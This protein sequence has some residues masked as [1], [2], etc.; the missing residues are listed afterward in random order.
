MTKAPMFYDA[1]IIGGG[2]AGLAAAVTYMRRRD[3]GRLVILE[4]KESCGRKLLATGNGRC[5]V[6]N[7]SA[8]GYE[9]I[10]AFFESMGVLLR[11]EEAG[12]AYPMSGKAESVL[13]ALLCALQSPPE[14]RLEPSK[15]HLEPVPTAAEALRGEQ[16]RKRCVDIRTDCRVGEILRTPGGQG[17]YE[18]KAENGAL[19][20]APRVLIATGGKAGPAF[21]SHGDG[22]AFARSLGHRVE[23]IRPALVPVVYAEEV[24][25]QFAAL[26]GVRVR[27][28]A[29]LEIDGKQS[30]VSDG[31]IQFTED[32]LSGIVVFD[33][34]LGMPKSI[35][36]G[37][38]RTEVCLDLVPGEPEDRLVQLIAGHAALGLEGVLPFKLADR[39]AKDCGGAATEMAACAKRF[40]IPVS[41]TKGWKE[42]QTTRG[43]VPLE[44]IDEAT[45]ESRISPGLFFAGE[46]IDAD[47]LCGGFNLS[48]AWATGI[49]AGASL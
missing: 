34:S 9:E 49:R 5:N 44:E 10:K 14:P 19:Y 37:R 38:P 6:S 36:E 18:I 15:R 8:E 20:Q 16:T 35:I 12:R 47:F 33:I 1:V 13:A 45:G 41:G 43:G 40:V 27:A 21:G 26:K 29:S 3:A 23:T 7:L 4:S 25:E 31:E 17:G 32:A 22:F 2:A 24:R 48:F 42:A 28:R 46:V 11:V 39:I 30:A